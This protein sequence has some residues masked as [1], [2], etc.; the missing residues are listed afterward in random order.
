MIPKA[1]R[2]L[3]AGLLLATLSTMA[4]AQAGGSHAE[5]GAAASP[6]ALAI[7][8]PAGVPAAAGAEDHGGHAPLYFGAALFDQ[9][10]IRSNGRG[11]PIYAWEGSA[12]YGTDYHRVWVNSRGETNKDGGGLERAE[13]QMLYS[14]LI[15]Y[16]WD[17]QAGVRHDFRLQP[18][19]GTP[20]RTYGMV[21]L[22]GLAPGFF[23]VQLQ[24][25][26]GEGG[27]LLARAAVSYD[28]LITNRLILQPEA[29]LNFASGWDRDALISPG[30]YRTEFGVRL[31][32]EIT[33]E[34]A[35]YIGYSYESF[36][37]GSSGLSRRLEQKPSQST[38]VAGIRLFF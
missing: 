23:E 5:H 38:V 2:R 15:G 14:R 28:L 21:A 7:V 33:R 35:P 4:W 3:A 12:Y 10:E 22:Q 25:F 11:S 9:N 30:I 20:S 36:N 16:Y 32:Y 31:R 18:K 26:F 19:D 37:G 29:E 34:F 24:A 17:A 6:M 27:V 1:F 8:T 13:L